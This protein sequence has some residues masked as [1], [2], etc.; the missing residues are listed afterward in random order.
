MERLTRKAVTLACLTLLSGV[1]LAV[2]QSANELPPP[3]QEQGQDQ[4]EQQ[5]EAREYHETAHRVS[6]AARH[7]LDG[8]C[9]FRHIVND[10]SIR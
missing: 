2:A 3:A 4:Q 7:S 8:P 1:P 5:E 6:P 10:G 9:G